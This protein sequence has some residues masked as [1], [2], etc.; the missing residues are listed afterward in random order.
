MQYNLQHSLLTHI[1]VKT[2]IKVVWIYDGVKLPKTKPFITIEQMQNNT[3]I[4]SKRRE[5]VRTIYRFQIGLFASSATDRALK[6]DELKR[7]LLFD[8]IE[9]LDATTPGRYSLGF[10]N[11]S[12]T[13]EVPM[14][15]EDV[16]DETKKHRI[17]FDVEVDVTFNKNTL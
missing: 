9:L 11:A 8:E 7:V 4:L 3:T 10:F 15:A 12:I 6:Q 13:A 14:P 17:Y 16:S 2:G 5:A 1:E